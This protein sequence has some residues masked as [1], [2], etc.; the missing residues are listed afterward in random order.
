[1]FNRYYE[2]ELN[3][4][5]GLAVE[6]AQ[7]NPALAPML[8]GTS[9]DPDVER[10][11]EGVAFLTGLTRQKLD[12]EFPEFVQELAN[13]LFPHYLQPVPASTMIAFTPKGPLA[14]PARVPAGTELASLPVDGTPCRFRTTADLDVQP[15]QLTQVSVQSQAGTAP[16]LVLDFALQGLDLSQWQADRLRL[17]LGGGYGDA[18]RL[19]L[20]LTHHVTAVCLS[21]GGE[22]FAPGPRCL[23]VSGF[24][25]AMLPYPSHAFQGYQRLQEFFVQPEK[26]LFVDIEGLQGWTRR[27]NG[28]AFSVS[29]TLDRLPE[30]MPEIRAGSVMINVTPAINLF[31]HAADP[32]SHEHR[33]S[34]YRVVPEGRDRAHY[35][36]YS[37]D[38]VVGYQQGAAQER[39]YYPF[40]LY[41]HDGRGAKLSYRATQRQ[42]TVG[43]GNE[44]FLSLNYPPGDALEPETLSI[45]ITCTNRSLPE[46]LRLGDISQPTSTSPD[47]LSFRNIRPVTPAQEP[48][49]GEAMLWRLI[50][51]VSLNFLSIAD[52]PTLQGMLNL[53]VHGDRQEQGAAA[54]NRRRIDGIQSVTASPETRLVG[55]GGVLR[56]QC[57]RIRCRQD[58]YAGIGD[59]YLFGCVLEHFLADYAGINSYTRVELEDSL[60][61]ML[62]KWPPR[63]GQQ[64]LL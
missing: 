49:T 47:R 33:A 21:G 61:G 58:Y 16:V 50:S 20:L 62:F 5:K 35:R 27:G 24:D 36:V 23:R 26:F 45:R 32:I 14:E 43:R 8:S 48:P 41:R 52:A 15:L 7:H 34:E 9:A 17:F 46:S 28:T 31:E 13:L 22:R 42:A 18:T 6:F 3:K 25:D 1:M 40:G 39:V 2:D 57:I 53:Y 10:L 44:T 30:W 64:T 51:H 29:I 37:I 4:L 59:L 55:R 63:L 60:S 56:G 12:D 19:L 38:Q 11:L 54:A